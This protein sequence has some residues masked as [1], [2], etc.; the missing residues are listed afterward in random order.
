MYRVDKVWRVNTHGPNDDN[1][2]TDSC[3]N[4]CHTC[5]KNNETLKDLL[6]NDDEGNR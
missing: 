6:E 1:G 5:I 4:G 3:K 2:E